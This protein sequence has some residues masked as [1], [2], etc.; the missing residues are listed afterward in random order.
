MGKVLKLGLI[1]GKYDLPVDDYIFEKAL[2]PLDYVSMYC[3]SYRKLW[4]LR[5][6][7]IQKYTDIKGYPDVTDSFYGTLK[8]YIRE[9]TPEILGVISAC[10]ELGLDLIIYHYRKDTESYESEPMYSRFYN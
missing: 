9:L 1:R 4:G 6:K 5:G 8:L 7:P 10:Y 3:M 2:N